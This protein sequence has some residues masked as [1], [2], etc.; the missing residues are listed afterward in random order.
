M[1]IG[2]YSLEAEIAGIGRSWREMNAEEYGEV[3]VLAGSG[4]RGQTQGA[5]QRGRPDFADL[6]RR[7][8]AQIHLRRQAKAAVRASDYHR[9]D[10]R[11][12]VRARAMHLRASVAIGVCTGAVAVL[13]YPYWAP[14]SWT[15]SYLEQHRRTEAIVIEDRGEGWIGVADRSLTARARSGGSPAPALPYVAME[16]AP[17]KDF[18]RLLYA[19]EDRHIGT[20]RSIHGIDV[21]GVVRGLKSLALGGDGP[22]GSALAAQ[23]VRSMDGTNPGG[24]STLGKLRRK[25]HE[26]KH[27]PLLYHRLGGADSPVF[28]SYLARHLTFVIGAPGSRMG[29]PLHGLEL[30]SQVVFGTSSARLLRWQSAIFAGA[31]KAPIILA[32]ASS[33]EGVAARDARWKR[34]QARAVRALQLAFP[35]DPGLQADIDAIRAMPAP[36]GPLGIDGARRPAFTL[37]AFQIWANPEVR[38]LAHAS[39]ELRAA[40][41]QLTEAI[42][43]EEM[44]QLNGIRLT[45][46]AEENMRFKLRL[47]RDLEAAQDR[48][49]GAL[50][51]SLVGPQAKADIIAALVED[52]RIVRFYANMQEPAFY[53]G[54][55][56]RDA[57]GRYDPSKATR[58]IGSTGKAMLAPLLGQ[59]DTVAT[60]YCNERHGN[61]QNAGGGKGGGCTDPAMWLP[62]RAVYGQSYNLP[63]IWRLRNFPDANLRELA[64]RYGLRLPGRLKPSET[65]VLGAATARPADMVRM[66]DAIGRGAAGAPAKAG[67]PTIV[68]A[69]R[70]QGQ[71]WKPWKPGSGM[72]D[73]SDQFAKAGAREFVRGV[74]SAPVER[75]G[76]LAGVAQALGEARDHVGKSGTSQAGNPN[77]DRGKFAIGS[78]AR[79]G[80][81]YAYLLMVDGRD[82]AAGLASTLA[83]SPLYPS[84]RTIVS[85]EG[86][87]ERER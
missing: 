67:L 26:F 32:P 60:R 43:P 28:Q 52:G 29:T 74:L 66:I 19:L 82:P 64:G 42:A 70:I 68:S 54:W 40:Y 5:T 65:I 7:F 58:P 50:A 39:A 15:D 9:A 4:H 14:S 45:V 10:T 12:R 59:S 76:T 71:K 38:A 3:L 13:A 63:L 51:G 34:V 73:I 55:N 35:E 81:R 16:A 33:P 2:P 85:P 36:S 31:V 48:Y 72:L 69:F 87:A 20:W 62:A 1:R 25:G 23:L 8:S 41:G 56:E 27:A 18:I 83:W 17:P 79:G 11:R 44:R 22:G 75:G 86:A 30:S 84:L 57:Q 49:G 78:F 80:G 53:G 61:V 6:L 47:H 77:R 37:A 21:L 46:D 24:Q